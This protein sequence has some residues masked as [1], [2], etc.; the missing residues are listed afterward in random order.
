MKKKIIYFSLLSITSFLL[1]F[2]IYLNNTYSP[3]D[4]SNVRNNIYVLSSDTLAGRLAGSTE[5]SMTGDI[6]KNRFKNSGLTTLN[7][8][9]NYSQN[10]N[11]ICP[12]ITNTSPYLKIESNGEIEEE[13]KYGVD[14]KEDMINFKNNTFYFSA[15]DKINSYLAY[16]EVSCADG[17]FLIY[18]PKDNN[19]SF[20][21]SFFSDFAKDAVIM[22]SNSTFEKISNGLKEGKQ[23]SIHIPFEE[24]EKT[25]SNIVGVI[26][27]SNSSLPPFIITAHYDH[28]GKDGLGNTYSG[29]LDNASGSSFLLELSRSLATYGKPERDIIFVALNAEEFGLLGSKAFAESNLFNIQDSKVINFDMIGSADYPISFMQGSKFKNTNSE[30]LNSLK[31]LCESNNVSYEVLYED[32]SDHASFNN[33]NIDAVSFCHSDKTR[34]HTPSDTLEYIDTNAIDVVYSIVDKEIKNSCYSTFTRFMYSSKSLLLISI[35]LILLICW[36][37]FDKGKIITDKKG[38]RFFALIALISVITSSIFYYRG[39]NEAIITTLIFGFSIIFI[40][41]KNFKLISK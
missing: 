20:R 9:G 8:D 17:N 1:L 37:I 25:I 35:M 12:V 14:F 15:S 26:N 4:S 10:F 27:G 3:F 5:N 23:I 18:V 6:I 36:G 21:S 32:S 19:F 40:F 24:E 13:L 31:E 7:N 28:L 33:L 39:Y 41:L 34:I 16:M 11:T 22:V 2:T 29:A 38:S 30:L